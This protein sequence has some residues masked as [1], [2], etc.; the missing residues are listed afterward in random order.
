MN[1][2][3]EFLRDKKY[4]TL[5]D[6]HN[7]KSGRCFVVGNGPSLNDLDLSLL[8]DEDCFSCNRIYLGYDKWNLDFN[9][10]YWCIEDV[11]VARDTVYE[12]NAL[13]ADIKFLPYELAESITNWSNICL[14]NQIRGGW[15]KIGNKLLYWPDFSLSPDRVYHGMTVTYFMLQVAC[16]MGYN[17]IYLIGIDHYYSRTD[18]VREVGMSEGRLISSG[19]DPDHFTPDYF[20][21]GRKYHKPRTDLTTNS[22]RVAQLT[23]IENNIEIYNASAKTKLDVFDRVDYGSL[24]K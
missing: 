19:D 12:W 3:I 5:H 23:A 15:K 13:E 24:F 7:T 4:L 11:R 17:P 8:K 14:V 18:D 6:L 21:E 16:M 10:P 20:G 1:Q 2:D 9:F 22:Y